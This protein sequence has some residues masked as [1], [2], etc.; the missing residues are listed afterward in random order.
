MVREVKL[1]MVHETLPRKHARHPILMSRGRLSCS[2]SCKL[3]KDKHRFC[4]GGGGGVVVGLEY[5]NVTPFHHG[6]CVN[7]F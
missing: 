4:L 7:I 6:E 2:P 1:L 3:I 5:I